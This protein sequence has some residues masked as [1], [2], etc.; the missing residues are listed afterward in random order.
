MPSADFTPL[1]AF[2]ALDL[3]VAEILEVRE[4]PAARKP[5]FQLVLDVGEVGTLQTSAQITRY[6]PADLVGRKVITAV[7]LG[8][9]RIAG[10]E[11]QCLVLAALDDGN[12]P[13][14]LS[15][16]PGARPGDRVA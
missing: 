8:T 4:F 12:Q 7:N 6:D 14:L 15:V 1:E 2:A 5:A 9:R 16:D 11:S 10:F 3:R 13:H